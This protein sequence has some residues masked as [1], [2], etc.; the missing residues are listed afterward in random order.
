[1]TGSFINNFAHTADSTASGGVIYNEGRQSAIL[2]VILSAITRKEKYAYG[3]AVYNN[4][5]SVIGNISG[6]FI[7]NAVQASYNAEGGAVYNPA[8]SKIGILSATL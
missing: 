1:M 5:K 2:P 4:K 3:G 6:D 7:D 8:D